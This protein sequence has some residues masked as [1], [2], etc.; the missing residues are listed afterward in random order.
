MT[1]T[2]TRSILR[3][4]ALVAA[5]VGVRP[6]AGATSTSTSTS[7][8]TPPAPTAA[9]S[10][11]QAAAAALSR[12]IERHK[13]GDLQG[14]VAAY[15]ES[16]RLYPTAEA[17]SNLGAAL[18]ALGRYGEAIDA[19]RGALALAP[20]DGRIRYN[21]ALAY[22]KS[23]DL[24]RAA[25]ELQALHARAPDDERATLL[26]ADC[27]LQ[28]GDPTAVEALLRPLAV[29]QPENR[30]VTYLLGMALVRSGKVDEGQQLVDK[31]VRDGDSPEAQYLVGSAAFMAG[32]YPR[33]AERFA[34]ALAL[35][36][37][38]PSLRS[39]YGRALLFTGDADGAEKAL[40][41][42]LADDPNDYDSAYYLGSILQ[43][44]GRAAEARP[45][46]EKALR[47][48]PPS[49]EAKELLAA[50][51]APE[52]AAAPVDPVSPLI[53]HPA[54]D[55]VLHGTDGKDFRLSSLRG[56]PLVLM[57]GSYTCPQLRNGAPEVNR[58]HAEYEDRAR[59]LLAYI[60]EAHPAGDG[61]QS[62]VNV[63]ENVSLPEARSLEERG[64]H[65]AECRRELKIPYEA[66]LDG[67]DG[68]VEAAFTAFPSRVFVID[69]SGT[70][71][72]SSALDAEGFRPK[73]LRAAI[74]AVAR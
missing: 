39:Y 14:A 52:K 33:A 32:D 50:L 22:Y 15:R 63:R 56:R 4:G 23:A 30:A 41:D 17:G 62:T 61:W 37:K 71:T 9:G 46:A 16:L 43:T 34:A 66:A 70:V 26:L 72:F 27:R 47:L 36:P 48:R 24:P 57:I 2:S 35:N 19:Y 69:R 10:P 3:T 38:L 55:V 54:P 13:A 67:M 7:A 58:L 42:A 74:E 65:A 21:L 25:E 5:L 68:Q 64:E 6:V 1:S 40:R 31:L 11:A 51:D 18:A 59:F 8:A 44:L 45:F 12:A 73:A 49:R 60:R 29:G 28:L 53:G 20:D